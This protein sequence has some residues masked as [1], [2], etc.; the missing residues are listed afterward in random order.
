MHC[1]IGIVQLAEL[2]QALTAAFGTDGLFDYT[3]I[4]ALE[5]YAYP[6]RLIQRFEMEEAI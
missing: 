2:Q 3:N 5:V 6:G 4:A 1:T